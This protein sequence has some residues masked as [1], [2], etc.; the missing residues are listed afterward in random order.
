[1]WQGRV[2]SVSLGL[3]FSLW[4]KEVNQNVHSD[5]RL[6]SSPHLFIYSCRKA[7]NGFLSGS[8]YKQSCLLKTAITKSPHRLGGNLLP[9]L[10]TSCWNYSLPSWWLGWQFGI[11]RDGQLCHSPTG[12]GGWGSAWGEA[13]L[14]AWSSG[15]QSYSFC[16]SPCGI[17]SKVSPDLI[18]WLVCELSK[19]WESFLLCQQG[20]V[21]AQNTPRALLQCVACG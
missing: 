13:A 6:S 3:G 9:I 5:T 21:L 19:Q 15:F 16:S 17:F 12:G 2:T 14:G 18:H 20:P 7:G 1:M 11:A 4:K 8:V 10:S